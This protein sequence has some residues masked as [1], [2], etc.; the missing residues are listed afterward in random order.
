MD[1]AEKA[2]TDLEKMIG[3]QIKKA[4]EQQPLATKDDIKRIED[5]LDQLL[6]KKEG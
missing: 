4:M 1:N 6:A 3:D 2:R 5:K